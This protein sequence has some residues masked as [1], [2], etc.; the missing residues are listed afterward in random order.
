MSQFWWSSQKKEKRMSW[1]SWEK[2][3]KSKHG[4]GMGFRELETFNLALLAKQGWRILQNPESLV[5]SILK[6]KYFQ[7]IP[8]LEVCAGSRPSYAWQSIAQS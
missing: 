7:D 6:E 8:F 1:L 5:A 2:L 3:G 4:G